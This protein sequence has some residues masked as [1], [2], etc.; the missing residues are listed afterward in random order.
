MNGKELTFMVSGM[1]WRDSLVMQDRETE[2]LWSHVTGE[3][4]R[5]PLKLRIL[6]WCVWLTSR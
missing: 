5:G 3:A 1:L 4:I 6:A 2:T